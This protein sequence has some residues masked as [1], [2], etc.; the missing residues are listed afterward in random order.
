MVLGQ[1]CYFGFDDIRIERLID[2]LLGEQ[3]PDGGWNCR[4]SEG[5][6]HSSFHTTMSVLEGLREYGSTDRPRAADASTAAK[7]GRE[8]LLTHR[9]FKS[10]QTGDVVSNE[11]TRFHFP[12]HWHYDVLRGLDYFRSCGAVQDPRLQD[13]MQLLLSR[14]GG[15]RRWRLARNYPGAA[16]FPIEIAGEPSRWN[17]LR[18]L[19]VLRWWRGSLSVASAE[20]KAMS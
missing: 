4:R 18:A 8:F 15:D 3:M 5:A 7:L 19:R 12:P 14:Q 9:L 2:Y 10:H 11:L 6:V 16:H 17:T 1:V 13:A 20:G